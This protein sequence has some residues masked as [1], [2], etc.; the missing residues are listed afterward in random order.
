VETFPRAN[1]HF[2]VIYGFEGRNAHQTLGM[3]LTRRMERAGLRPIGFVATDYA[4]AVWGLRA[5]TSVDDLLDPDMLGDDLEEWMQ[6]STMMKRSFRVVATIAGLIEKTHPGVSK[7]GRQ[8][9]MNSDLIYDVLLRHQPDHILIRATRDDAARGLTDIRRL[10]DMLARFQGRIEFRPLERVSPL[11]MPLMLEVGRES[12]TASAVE[13][14]LA[15]LEAE[16][17][18]EALDG[19]T[20]APLQASLPL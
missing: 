10:A 13:D 20:G 8:M 1:K 11:A 19:F 12:V 14:S 15:E 2:L 17:I 9:T 7:T 4:L 3:L 16:L 5:V 6:E 18:D